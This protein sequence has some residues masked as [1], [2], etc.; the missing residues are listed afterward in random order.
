MERLTKCHDSDSTFHVFY[1]LWEGADEDLQKKLH[2][3]SIDKPFIGQLSGQEDRNAAKVGW[4]HLM[5]AL[6]K[7]QLNENQIQGI[8]NV[9]GAIFHLMHSGATNNPA[10]RSSFIRTQNAQFAAE[11]LGV[12]FDQLNLAVFR[13]N[14]QQPE[15]SRLISAF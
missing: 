1:Y 7:L 5:D 14:Q 11:L 12:Q 8:S 9:L 4:S 2:F 10:S 6:R 3:H 15:M 13:G